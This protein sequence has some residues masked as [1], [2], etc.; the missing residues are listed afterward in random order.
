MAFAIDDWMIGYL[1]GK[2]ADVAVSKFKTKK[3]FKQ[4]LEGLINEVYDK[5]EKSHP[6]QSSKGAYQF[7]GAQKFIDQLLEFRFYKEQTIDLDTIKNELRADKNI[8]PFTN[9]DFNEYITLFEKIV[10]CDPD[11]K[12]LEVNENYKPEVFKISK[13]TDRIEEKLDAL[14]N[15]DKTID[16]IRKINLPPPPDK[17]IGRKAK[18]EEVYKLLSSENELVLVNGLGGIGKTTIAQAYVNSEKYT[19]TYDVLAWVKVFGGIKNEFLNTFATILKIEL[20]GVDP[21]K[22]FQ[23]VH[24]HLANIPGQKLLVIDNVNDLQDL[25][26]NLQNIKSLGWKV[27][28]TSRTNPDDITKINVDELSPGDARELFLSHYK[29]GPNEVDVEK[30]DQLLKLIYYHTLFIEQLAKA[31]H[32][33]HIGIVAAIE[34]IKQSGFSDPELQRKISAGQHAALTNREKETAIKDYMV[35]LFEP[36]K[37]D[38]PLQHILMYFAVFPPEEVEPGMLK[39]LFNIDKDQENEFEDKLEDLH[40][41]GWLARGGISYKMHGLVQEVIINRLKPDAEKCKPLL[42]LLSYYLQNLNITAAETLLPF[43]EHFLNTIESH[44]YESI[45]LGWN[46]SDNYQEIGNLDKA[47]YW[48][49]YANQG[50]RKVNDKENLAMSYSKLGEIYKDLGDFDTSLEFFIKSHEL[51]KVLYSSNPKSKNVKNGLAISY[52]KLG[53]IY[54]DLGDFD[55]SL[56]FFTE[57]HSLSKELYSSSPKSEDTKNRLANSYGKLGEIY[58]ALGDFDN[59]LEFFTKHHKFIKQLYSDNPKSESL[60]NNVTISYEKLGEIY[61]DLGDFDKS[62]KYYTKYHELTK[63]FFSINPKS[64]SLKNGLAFSFERLGEIHQALGDFDKSLEFYTQEVKLFE[65]LYR[66]NP[67]SER[68]KN[69]LSISYSKLGKTYQDLGDFDKS[70]EH[71]IKSHEITKELYTSNPRSE[72]LKHSLSISY[73][74]LGKIYQ[75]L[76]DLNKSL[77]FFNKYHGL[78][79]ELCTSN[80][81]S[82][83]IKISFSISYSKL[84]SIYQA[85]GDLEKALEFFTKGHELMKELTASNPNS[86]HLKNHLAISYTKLGEIFQNLGNLNFSCECYYKGHDLTKELNT[87]NPKSE[88]LKNSLA[89]SY[90]ILGDLYTVKKDFGNAYKHGVKANSLFAEIFSNNR[91]SI[92]IQNNLALSEKKLGQLLYMMNPQ[93]DEQSIIKH[94][95]NAMALWN[96][97]YKRTGISGPKKQDEQVRKMFSP[98]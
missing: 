57:C 17:L 64:E 95:Q 68:L 22:Q 79:K 28:I 30:L 93:E 39:V 87:S 35:S 21:K 36:E 69:G 82:E 18:L 4:H 32:K 48:A 59:T 11:I 71:Y 41:M 89:V 92:E 96:D 45:F 62:L 13:Q 70:L 20:K 53:E 40:Q 43:A 74:K 15:K 72:K 5:F 75:D 31:C 88:C 9:D 55:A 6:H 24:H 51:S 90:G 86:E 54:Q 66:S 49:K 27:I 52:A 98:E 29:K 67:K 65:E 42:D 77:K 34:K 46:L 50:L 38:P 10:S 47:L 7:F 56:E 8:L 84:G 94:M 63:E 37:I 81:K 73:E 16:N 2:L 83:K 80:P 76:G 91:N 60:K 19:G 23:V 97:L 61:Q 58:Q 1:F 33:K 12:D 26:N 25:N 14:A 44:N 3:K 78:T 85:F